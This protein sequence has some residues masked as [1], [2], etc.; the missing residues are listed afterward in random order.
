MFSRTL[1]PRLSAR[2]KAKSKGTKIKGVNKAGLIKYLLVLQVRQAGLDQL[3]LKT[4]N[5]FCCF[6]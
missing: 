6:L 3:L 4:I 1:D 5:I 2:G